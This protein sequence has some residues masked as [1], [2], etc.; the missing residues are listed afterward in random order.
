[1]SDFFEKVKANAFKTK[2]EAVKIGK[3]VMDKAGNV[4]SQ[5]KLNFAVSDAENKIKEIYTE[6]GKA[7]YS[8]Y[9]EGGLLSEDA[10]ENCEKIDNLLKEIDA[11]K[12]QIAELKDSVKCP[13]CGSLNKQGSSFCSKCGA[14]VENSKESTEEER[15]AEEV[16]DEEESAPETVKKVITIKAKKPESADND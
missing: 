5:T 1:M 2:D 11:L 12:E 14:P 3:Q 7:V 10:K 13:N 9:K 6:M 8:D 16:F 15:C 4:V